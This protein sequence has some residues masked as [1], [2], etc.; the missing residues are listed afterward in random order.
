MNE[1]TPAARP[2]TYQDVIDAPPHMVAEIV[3]GRLWT[4]P[5]PR[6]QHGIASSALAGLLLP[7]FQFGD[8]PGGWLF[9][10]EPELHLGDAVLVPDLAGWRR[11]RLPGP[12]TGPWTD[13]P[14]DWVCET[15]SPS[16]RAYDLTHKRDAYGRLGVRHLWFLDPDARMLETFI[17]RDGAWRLD[18]AFKDADEVRAAPFDAVSLPLDRLWPDALGATAPDP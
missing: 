4:H 13:V 17:H 10:V 7:P 11:E 15:L 1:M 6:L 5:R 16:T 12:V 8:D 18:G 3:N 9:I 2:A 14:P